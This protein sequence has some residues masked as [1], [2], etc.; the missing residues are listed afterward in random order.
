MKILV[1]MSGGVDSSVA[2]YLLKKAGFE[3]GGATI[4]TWASGDCAEKNTKACCGIIGVEDA[5]SVARTLEIPYHVFNFETEFKTHV[6]D[7]FSSEYMAGR[8]PN[9]CIACNQ[10][11]KFRLFLKRARALGYDAIA[12]GHYAQVGFD[13][14]RKRYFIH[15]GNDP[16]KDQSYVLFP[17]EQDILAHLHLPLGVYAKPQIRQIAREAGLSTSDKPDSQEICFIPSND[18]GAF[19]KREQALEDRPGE[20]RDRLGNVLGTH[21]G[22]YH[23][24]VGQR[25]G[26][27]VAFKHPLYVTQVLPSENAIVVGTKEE[28]GNYSCRVNKINWFQ[29]LNGYSERRI[30]AKIRSH[31][32]KAW[33]VLKKISEH[34]AEVTFDEPQDAI[35]PG[36]ACVFYDGAN[37]LG[38]GWIESH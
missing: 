31:H 14:P 5:R 1:A 15:E 11:I 12:T 7:Y 4:R 30:Q 21:Q 36:Q 35:T 27:G 19:L 20:I 38:G 37:V 34:E 3:V 28:A 29:N 13:E 17:L 6:V 32:P 18:Y 16:A 24:T 23:Y 33:G 8:T 25:K 9:P 2:A 10:H 22:Y 26:I